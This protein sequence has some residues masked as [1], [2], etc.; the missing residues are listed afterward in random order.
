MT[1]KNN[2]LLPRMVIRRWEKNNGHLFIKP[3]NRS[4]K[5][6]YLDYSKK[7]Y[8]S[9]G[10]ED[11]VLENR[12]AVFE[13][14]IASILKELDE[15]KENF[16]LSSFDACILSLYVILQSCRNDNTSPVITSDESGIYQNNNYL[17][18]VPLIT[19]Q[20][21]AVE[22][23]SKICDDF[24]TLIKIKNG[25]ITIDDKTVLNFGFDLSFLH[26]VIVSNPKDAF[27]VS[28]TT[29]VMECDMD[30]NY[31]YTYV[32]ISSKKGLILTKSKY[33]QDDE[34]IKQTKIRFGHKYGLGIPDEYLSL[35][36][37]DHKLI[38][39]VE[40]SGTSLT[41]KVIELSDEETKSLNSII[42]QGGK[43]ILYCN[44][45]TLEQ[46]KTPLLG[47]NVCVR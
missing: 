24:E 44:K 3:T 34:T 26:L 31:L 30:G 6:R 20:E 10:K 1:K 18:G 42:Y 5:I 32:P 27:L 38:N 11:D 43:K 7:Y 46:A 14:Y 41:F 45:E 13:S 22:I 25:K 8:Y 39:N 16:T 12:I 21:E 9:L 37:D 29:A 23:T 17:F 47:R 2:H 40:Q 35:I 28:E 19:T 36:I 4:R 15:A 33:F